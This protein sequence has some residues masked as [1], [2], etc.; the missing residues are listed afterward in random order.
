MSKSAN[1]IIVY[2]S[3]AAFSHQSESWSMLYPEPKSVFKTIVESNT[4]DSNFA[5]C[6]ATKDL[7]KNTFSVNSAIDENFLLDPSELKEKAMTGVAPESLMCNDAKIRIVK[8]RVSTYSDYINISYNMRWFFVASEPVSAKWTAPYFPAKSPVPDSLFSPG[9]FDIGRWIRAVGVDMHIPV[10]STSF[11]IKRG[12]PLA[13]LEIETHKKV[14]FKRFVPSPT[15]HAIAEE[16]MKSPRIYGANFK[17]MDRY[18]MAK[19]SKIMD[20]A[21]QEILKSI[22]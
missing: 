10:N 2:W 7:L 19:D 21:K 1:E 20:I 9:R 11:N 16:C 18:N 17:L 8:E 4:K 5:M 13:F 12:D 15:F 6:P 14:I 3:P 22:I